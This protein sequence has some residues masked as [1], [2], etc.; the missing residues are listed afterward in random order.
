MGVT[1]TD[2]AETVAPNIQRLEANSLIKN[3]VITAIGLGLIPLPLVD[4]AAFVALQVK[5]VHGLS[6]VYDIPF[7][8]N[9]GRS[10]IVSLLSGVGSLV[11]IM[12][13]ASLAKIFPVFGSL[14]GGVGVAATLGAITY[15]VGHVFATHFEKGGT[16]L[17]F[18][19]KKMQGLFKSKLKEGQEVAAQEQE[20]K[21]S[22][23]EAPVAAANT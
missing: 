4:M 15:A 22:S 10:L 16:L 20:A 11:G 21:K 14:G 1:E 7:K 18:N 13:I 5:L 19:P 8:Q 2:A 9:L 3:Y 12:G 6:K 17:D 23:K